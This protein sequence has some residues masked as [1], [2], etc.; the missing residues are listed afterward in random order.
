MAASTC[1]EMTVQPNARMPIPHY[2]DRWGRKR[3]TGLNRHDNFPPF[4]RQGY[5][6]PVP[7]ETVFIKRG[8]VHWFTQSYGLN[9][10]TLPLHA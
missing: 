6:R 5:R 3:F 10:Q 4:G 8:I 1:F 9:R 2:H 7:G